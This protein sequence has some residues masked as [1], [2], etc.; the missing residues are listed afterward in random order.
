MILPA[1]K[2]TTHNIGFPGDCQQAKES[3]NRAWVKQINTATI[4]LLT[5]NWTSTL[6]RILVPLF[7][8]KVLFL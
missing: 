7:E 5:S 2:Y 8:N 1:L 4:M 3:M 6:P